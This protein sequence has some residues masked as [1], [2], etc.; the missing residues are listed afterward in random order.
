MK[1]AVLILSIAAPALAA[2]DFEKEIRP[3]LRER[4]AECHGAE[5]Q[6]G[7]LRLDARA[8]AMRSS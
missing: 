6:K 5:K 1:F 3:L 8:F 7:G 4:C 2:V